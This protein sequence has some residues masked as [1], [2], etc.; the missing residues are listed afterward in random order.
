[1]TDPVL[2]LG[3]VLSLGILVAAVAFVGA[4]VLTLDLRWAALVAMAAPTL[5]FLAIVALIAVYTLGVPVRR[6][7]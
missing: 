6:S 7:R 4:F 3:G 1:M 2:K 5:L